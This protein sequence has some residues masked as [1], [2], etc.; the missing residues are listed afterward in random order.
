MPI[1]RLTYSISFIIC[2]LVAGLFFTLDMLPDF[3]KLSD[4]SDSS[5]SSVHEAIPTP[6]P[7]ITSQPK[8]YVPLAT[9]TAYLLLNT[10]TSSPL[11]VRNPELPL[12]I[13]SITKLMTAVIV[14]EVMERTDTLTVT[15]EAIAAYGEAG[16]L[17]VGETLSVETLLHALLMESSNDA[18]ALFLE[19]LGRENFLHLMNEKAREL[20]MK[21]TSYADSSGISA[22]NISTAADLMKLAKYVIENHPTILEITRKKTYANEGHSF[23]NF[24]HFSSDQRFIGGK[25]GYTSAAKETMLGMFSEG[26]NESGNILFAIV[27]GSGNRKEDITALLKLEETKQQ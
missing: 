2:V 21:H 22:S 15:K 6:T 3:S 13:A 24:N 10:A 8:P 9:T 27:L 23:Y 4:K 18:A 20:D 12:P 19:T 25:T 5:S 1:K 16:H 26:Q 11:L 7:L 17:K 14:E